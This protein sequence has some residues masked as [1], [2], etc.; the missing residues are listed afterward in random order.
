MLPNTNNSTSCLLV[1]PFPDN[2][3]REGL[4]IW[5]VG[6]CV[7]TLREESH[8]KKGGTSLFRFWGG[9]TKPGSF[10]FWPIGLK[11]GSKKNRPFGPKIMGVPKLSQ[12][13]R[14]WLEKFQKKR[15]RQQKIF[16]QKFFFHPR[17]AKRQLTL[18]STFSKKV[19]KNT[20]SQKSQKSAKLFFW[21]ELFFS[22]FCP[23]FAAPVAP[24]FFSP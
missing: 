1:G 4:G 17:R 8:F 22:Y 20:K 14:F 24:L 9:G 18:K 6:K 16:S 21:S 10:G 19:N 12:K 3:G 2:V 5:P 23:I 7:L 11:K 13:G 15:A